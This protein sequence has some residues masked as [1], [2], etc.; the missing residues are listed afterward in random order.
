LPAVGI[1]ENMIDNRAGARP[2]DRHADVHADQF[3][4]ILIADINASHGRPLAITMPNARSF[5]VARRWGDILGLGGF[6]F[7]F[8]AA[9]GTKKRLL[10]GAAAT[11]DLGK[12][13]QTRRHSGRGGEVK[14]RQFLQVDRVAYSISITSGCASEFGALA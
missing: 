7:L 6:R 9:A 3:Q 5:G 4:R 14:A 1:A 11:R 8:T 10:C 2:F 12:I 13:R